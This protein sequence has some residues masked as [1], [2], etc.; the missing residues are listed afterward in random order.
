M[1]YFEGLFYINIFTLCKFPLL[2]SAIF[3]FLPIVFHAIIKREPRTIFMDHAMP[4]AYVSTIYMET[5]FVWNIYDCYS[6]H[7][8]QLYVLLSRRFRR[9]VVCLDGKQIAY[10]H[11]YCDNKIFT[12]RRR[13][14][15]IRSVRPYQKSKHTTKWYTTN[16]FRNTSTT[17]PF[18][19]SFPFTVVGKCCFRKNRKV[20]H[21]VELKR[22]TIPSITRIWCGVAAIRTLMIH[23]LNRL[24]HD[25]LTA[26]TLVFFQPITYVNR[27]EYVLTVMFRA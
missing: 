16:D 22:K 26:L 14:F 9:T 23:L 21:P 5:S 12:N 19:D 11:G 15:Y 2:P 6:P 27:F 1:S 18:P 13:M 17:H 25:V 10:C 3:H 20:S 8:L 7:Y 4:S 24:Q